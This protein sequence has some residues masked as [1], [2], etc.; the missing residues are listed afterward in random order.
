[1]ANPSHEERFREAV[2]EMSKVPLKELSLEQLTV[3][4]RHWLIVCARELDLALRAYYNQ[5]QANGCECELCKNAE[6]ALASEA[7]IK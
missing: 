2:K 6:H 3:E 4:K 7:F 5:H 1:M